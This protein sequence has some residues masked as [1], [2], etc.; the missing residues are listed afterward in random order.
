MHAINLLCLFYDFYVKANNYIVG[1]W[2]IDYS[3]CN[4]VKSYQP[5]ISLS[6]FLGQLQFKCTE[7][8]LCLDL[9]VA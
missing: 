8:K 7:Y 4:H 1:P 6:T 3:I 2:L 5:E 9:K